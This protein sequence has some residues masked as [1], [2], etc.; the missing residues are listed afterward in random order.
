M[1]NSGSIDQAKDIF[2]EAMIAFYENVRNE[3]FKGESAIG[4]YLY[5]IARFKWLN[6][7]K[8]DKVRTDHHIKAE[9]KEIMDVSPMAI[10][11]DDEKRYQVLQVL[12]I[13]GEPCRTIL[14][15]SIYHNASMKEIASS[16]NFSSEQVA[17]N[18][19]YKCLKRLKELIIERPSLMHILKSYG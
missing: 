2:Q 16:G 3:V 17:R 7:L 10:M 9:N 18:K 6:Q 13:L 1:A 4:T 15:E 11:I 14:I 5:S 8:K 19:K 12:E